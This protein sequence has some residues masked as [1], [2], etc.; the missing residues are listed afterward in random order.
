[1]NISVSENNNFFCDA[2]EYGKQHRHRSVLGELIHSDVCGP[3]KHT[4]VGGISSYLKMTILTTKGYFSCKN[5]VTEKLKIFIRSLKTQTGH[6]VKYLR[7][8]CGT[9]YLNKDV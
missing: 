1:M 8:D 9:E 4:L 3:M 7:T 2:C 6:K 5:E